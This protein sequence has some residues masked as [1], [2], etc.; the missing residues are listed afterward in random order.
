[1]KARDIIRGWPRGRSTSRPLAL[2]FRLYRAGVLCV[3]D[4]SNGMTVMGVD[5]RWM[6]DWATELAEERRKADMM[7][8]FY[9]LK[10][11]G[12]E[13]ASDWPECLFELIVGL[14]EVQP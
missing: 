4:E 11:I 7:E 5:H 1:M 14:S 9:V 10:R 12:G 3:L 8:M 13:Q 6:Q 2:S